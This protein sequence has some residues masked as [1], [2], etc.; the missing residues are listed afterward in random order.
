MSITIYFDLTDFIRY[1]ES[2]DQVTG[3]QRVELSLIASLIKKHGPKKIRAVANIGHGSKDWVEI[4]SS[5]LTS[6]GG[7]FSAIKILMDTGLIKNTWHPP[8]HEI[9]RFLSKYKNKKIIRSLKKIQIYFLSLTNKH[10]VRE[11]GLHFYE[12][13]ALRSDNRATPLQRLPKNSTFVRITPNLNDA[14]V[15]RFAS[16]AHANGTTVVQMVHDLV[17]IVHPEFHDDKMVSRF[18]GWLK[19]SLIYTNQYICVSSNTHKDLAAFMA[20][21]NV[22][23]PAKTV[24]LAHEFFG[25]S[26]NTVKPNAIRPKIINAKLEGTNFILCVGSIEIR[27]NGALLLKAW[28]DLCKQGKNVGAILVFA[29]K[30]GWK[31]AEFFDILENSEVLHKF[32]KIIDAPTD[33]E[34]AWLY[35]N[36]LFSVYPSLYEG[37]GLPVGEAAW[38][39]KYCI[40]SKSSSI[41]E[42][43][44]SLHDYVDPSDKSA[45]A[46]AIA[47]ALK[48]PELVKQRETDIRAAT[49]R[50]WSDVADDLY[51]A[52][53]DK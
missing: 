2:N 30:R 38:L 36:S 8:K 53:T 23:L 50:T 26:R 48:Y 12:D 16:S 9:K 41:P 4:D 11:M 49:L 24:A 25:Y 22:S 32:V 14:E 40:A 51:A 45:L 37:W 39:G 7:Q 18:R 20:T 27:K 34:L 52:L 10:R 13:M 6:E 28:E 31:V 46:Q 44:G 3:I 15:E 47:H 17:P 19:R 35:Q 21:E 42:V 1:C 43:C 29:G 33:D 5:R